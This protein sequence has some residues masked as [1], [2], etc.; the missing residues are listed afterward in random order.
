MQLTLLEMSATFDDKQFFVADNEKITV[1]LLDGGR[2]K[3]KAYLQVNGVLFAFVD[4]KAEIPADILG[5]FTACELQTRDEK[6]QILRRY[7]TNGLYRL[8]IDLEPL[9]GY[10]TGEKLAESVELLTE[11]VKML[12]ARVDGEA[13]RYQELADKVNGKYTLVNIKGE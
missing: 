5:K 13:V 7:P 10:E 6:G 9:K 1:E 4:G 3:D 8:P 12:T 2:L 11:C